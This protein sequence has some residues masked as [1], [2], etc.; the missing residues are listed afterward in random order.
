MTTMPKTIVLNEN[1][2]GCVYPNGLQVLRSSILRGGPALYGDA[3]MGLLP[4]DP[5][6][7]KDKFRPATE[8]DFDAF[9]VVFH[10]DYLEQIPTPPTICKILP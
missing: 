1:V 5:V 8:Q 9:G 7:D 4:F 10:P 6:L 2:L 3:G